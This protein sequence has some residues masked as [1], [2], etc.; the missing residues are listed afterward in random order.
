MPCFCVSRSNRRPY[1]LIFRILVQPLP[2]QIMTVGDDFMAASIVSYRIDC[3]DVTCSKKN[4]QTIK[5][6][7]NMKRR[8]RNVRNVMLCASCDRCRARKTRCD[9]NRPCAS[10]KIKY[11]RIH[12]LTPD[13]LVG[14]DI[15]EF[16]CIYSPA[17]RRGPVPVM[18]NSKKYDENI[19]QDVETKSSSDDSVNNNSD[20]NNHTQH[21]KA[22]RMRRRSSSHESL[23]RGSVT[24]NRVNFGDWA[25]SSHGGGFSLHNNDYNFTN[26]LL[27]AQSA[28]EN[29][30]DHNKCI[31]SLFSADFTSD[32]NT[33]FPLPPPLD[34]TA[35]AM[36]DHVIST[37]ISMRKMG[38]NMSIPSSNAA[39]G[40]AELINQHDQEDVLVSA[41][42]AAQKQLA[43]VQQLQIQHQIMRQNN[44]RRENAAALAASQNSYG[45]GNSF[46]SFDLKRSQH[47][48]ILTHESGPST[49]I[50]DDLLTHHMEASYGS[51]NIIRALLGDNNGHSQSM[52]RRPTVMHSNTDAPSLCSTSSKKRVIGCTDPKVL[53]FL[54]LINLMNPTGMHLRACHT[55]SA[56]G[57]FGLLPIPSDEEYCNR[58]DSSLKPQQLPQF[59]VA[60]L[61]AARFGE[62]AMGALATM[63]VGD[64][65]LMSSLANASVLC[66]KSCVE[67][68]IHPSLMLY[69]ARTFFF[70]SILRLYMGELEGYFKYRRF[71]LHYLSQMD[72][73][74]CITFIANISHIK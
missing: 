38:N 17:R 12:K 34:P 57:L 6:T 1:Q 66:L 59:D 74:I 29:T 68:Q 42:S 72:V 16:G 61:Q 23:M 33:I 32:N 5:N 4:G 18:N 56:G 15:A 10:C 19:I 69:V 47:S 8:Q 45:S 58:F 36:Q 67:E 60:A 28:P 20:H 53:Q 35:A 49:D 50:S 13:Q 9:G 46:D 44:R 39:A 27:S 30:N 63:K 2:G 48:S 52:S 41:Q 31:N 7:P 55:L 25:G 22:R 24:G 62:L 40:M 64:M 37:L 54:P 21:K 26:S 11:M 51:G 14:I 3:R 43:Y 71:C 65:E 73:S 70:H